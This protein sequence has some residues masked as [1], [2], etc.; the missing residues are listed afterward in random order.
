M[1]HKH[2]N[3]IREIFHDPISTNIQWREIESLL[4]HLGADVESLSGTR[5]RV[6]LNGH[7]GILHRPHGGNALGRQDVPHLREFLARGRVTPSLYE[8]AK[9]S[10]NAAAARREPSAPPSFEQAMAD[11]T[12]VAVI[13]GSLAK[14]SFNRKMARALIGV[15]PPSLAL[16]F[17]EIGDLPFYTPTSRPIRPRRC[18]SFRERI[19]R[20]RACSSSR[21]S[22]TARCRACS[23]TRST[24]A[25]GRTARAY[26]RAS[27]PRSSA[28]RP[29]RS[30]PSARITTCASRSSSS[31]CRRCSSPR[32]IS[33]GAAKLFDEQGALVN[34]GTREFITK[35]MQS[36]AQWIARFRGG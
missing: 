1:S 34:D 25:R 23:R 33:A 26:G 12:P 9:K 16:E 18:V 6:K 4:R 35:F 15:A 11:K 36:F 29:A 32:L 13:V 14:A 28:S 3:L 27:R 17:V 21:R 31:T 20:E 10:R 2:D 24:S 8:A 7:E 19:A 30:A 22:T 5:V